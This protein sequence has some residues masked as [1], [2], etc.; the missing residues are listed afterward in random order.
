MMGLPLKVI[1]RVLRLDTSW[2]K[3]PQ[4]KSNMGD[5]CSAPSRLAWQ[6]NLGAVFSLGLRTWDC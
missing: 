1:T 3:Y 4:T 5:R 6:G 2:A